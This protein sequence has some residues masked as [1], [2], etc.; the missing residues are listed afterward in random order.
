MKK[1]LLIVVLA[2]QSI[3]L[4]GMAAWNELHLRS[5]TE[6]LLETA[7]VDPRDLLRGDFVILNYKISTIDG[8]LWDVPISE[9]RGG[10]KVYVLLELRGE[11]HEVVRASTKRPTA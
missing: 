10:Q 6:I 5:G 4:A 11:F 9:L 8:T 3:F 7:P 2:L 1:S